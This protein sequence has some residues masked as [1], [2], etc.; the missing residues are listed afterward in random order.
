MTCKCSVPP[1]LPLQVTLDH[2]LRRFVDVYDSPQAP[3]RVALCSI[4]GEE[5]MPIFEQLC[6]L[7]RVRRLRLRPPE[8]FQARLLSAA[9]SISCERLA[10]LPCLPRFQWRERAANR[11][12]S[13]ST[14]SHP[15]VVCFPCPLVLDRYRRRT[16]AACPCT[17]AYTCRPRTPRDRVR[18][19][20]SCPYTADHTRRR[21]R[22]RAP[23]HN[24]VARR[25]GAK[26]GP[27]SVLFDAVNSYLLRPLILCVSLP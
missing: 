22:R 5:V 15:H 10:H 23:V 13:A 8:F 12:V 11:V 21:A 20:S 3:P 25:R 2:S 14:A 26:F 27:H 4:S 24:S 7:P 17:G 16:A 1:P 19:R 6:P 18:T 9:V